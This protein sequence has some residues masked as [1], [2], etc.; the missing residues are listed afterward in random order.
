MPNSNSKHAFDEALRIFWLE[1][2]REA[3]SNIS[4]KELQLIFS[5]T[6]DALEMSEA[7]RDELVNKLFDTVKSASLGQ[8]VTEAME[9]K[10]IKQQ[11]LAKA[12]KVPA[13]IIKGLKAD[14]VFPNN[15]PVLLLKNLLVMLEISF[16][17]V[18]R[19]ILKTFEIMKRNEYI[20]PGLITT[21]S[22]RNGQNDTN[23]FPFLRGSTARPDG[24][25][26]YE[27]KESLQKYISKLKE[28]METSEEDIGNV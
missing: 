28:L 4:E 1:H 21:V 15:I 16:Q 22:F 23:E 10:G 12:T 27:N 14:S 24:R 20:N 11:A 18:E 9:A 8:L 6:N 26:L 25:E 13:Y 2:A 7:K 5:S 19:A 17:K 3:D